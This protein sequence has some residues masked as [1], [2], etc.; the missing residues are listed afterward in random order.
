MRR[1]KVVRVAEWVAGWCGGAAGDGVTGWE[2]RDGGE[3]G[4]LLLLSCRVIA[5]GQSVL[6]MA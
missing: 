3:V 1:H 6:R 5:V 2:G 4:A